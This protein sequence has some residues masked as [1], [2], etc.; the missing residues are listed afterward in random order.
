MFRKKPIYIVGIVLFTL[1]LIADLVI[2]FLVPVS[3]SQATIPTKGINDFGSGSFGGS[4]PD[5]LDME[6]FAGQFPS[7]DTGSSDTAIPGGMQM[8]GGGS[9]PGFSGEMPEG[10]SSIPDFSG[11]MPDMSGQKPGGSMDDMDM[12]LPSGMDKANIMNWEQAAQTKSERVLSF[13]RSAFWPVLIVSILGDGLCILMLVRISRKKKSD[14]D[15]G[16]ENDEDLDTPR[17]PDGTN[18]VLAIVALL[19]VGA[20]ITTSLPTKEQESAMVANFSVEQA[21][22]EVN[23]IASVFSGSGTLTGS[24]PDTIQIPATVK[25]TSYTVKNGDTVQPGD[26]IANVDKTSVLLAI[27]EVQSLIGEMDAELNEV[28]SSALESK[29]TARADGRVKAIYVQAGQS[30]ADAMQENGA[31]VLLSLGGS[32]TVVIDSQQSLSVGQS[33]TVTLSDGM[34]I[35]GK[36]QQV[37][38]GKV[39]VTTSD[40]EP[41]PD[42]TVTVSAAD[43]TVLGTGTLSIS[44]PLRVTGYYGNVKSIKVSV[45]DKV[46]AGDTLLTLENTEDISRYQQ[47]LQERKMLAELLS[48]LNVMYQEGTVKASSSGIVS[49]I[50]SDAVYTQLSTTTET[51]SYA[52]LLSSAS[53]NASYAVVRLSNVVATVEETVPAEE[54]TPEETLPEATFPEATAPEAGELPPEEAAPAQHPDGI[55]AGQI[56]KVSYGALH[57]TVCE[58]DMTGITAEFLETM[59]EILF[60]AERQYS[61]E[62]TVPV[63]LY[64]NGQSLSSSVSALQAGDKVLL[65]VEDGQVARIDYIVGA[66][67]TTPPQ[68]NPGG[69]QQFPSGGSGGSSFGGQASTQTETEEAVYQVEKTS[70]CAIIPA[71]TM[72]IDVSVDELDILSISVGQEASITLDAL[73]GQS[74]TGAVKKIHT[75]G[76]NE[77]GSTKYTVTMEVARTQQMLD[78]MN[79][80]VLIEVSRLSSVLTVPAAAIYEDGNRTYVYTALDEKTGEPSQPVDV[81]TG[82]S[83]GTNIEILSGLS[84][85][86]TVYYSYADTIVYRFAK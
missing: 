71:E 1:L 25:I 75:S 61:P 55:Y 44:S 19:V 16:P 52:S 32:M 10:E 29:I 34:T 21:Q 59:D 64:L 54:V 60:T 73:P 5:G 86:D 70:P 66:V 8:P 27:Q 43:G 48:E 26:V 36:V 18:I 83:D 57:I 82:A 74:F 62:V 78:G 84:A 6:D 85:E 2:Y 51:P 38:D 14:S 47:L 56:S 28:Q 76:T 17:R 15:D 11:E 67:Q 3:G 7:G 37:R 65:Y 63:N 58:T 33:L 35:E 81:T 79:C 22:A 39:T 12:Q 9:M 31:V 24:D 23:D 80:S 20:V 77:G 46:E 40:S 30:I 53:G 42:D 49:Q 41:Q 45:G 50:D 4:R 72:T 13:A 68:G 69:N